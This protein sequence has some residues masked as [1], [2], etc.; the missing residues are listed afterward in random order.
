MQL[1]YNNHAPSHTLTLFE[2]NCIVLDSLSLLQYGT[3]EHVGVSK[4]NSRAI[5]AFQSADDAVCHV[6]L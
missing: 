2:I 6:M 4:K 5:I 3:L 1:V